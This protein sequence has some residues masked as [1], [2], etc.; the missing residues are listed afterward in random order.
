MKR[1][2]KLTG[3]DQR[4]YA[5]DSIEKAMA[6]GKLHRVTIEPWTE[7]R[8][9]QQNNALHLYCEWL[10]E[11]LNNNGFMRIIKIKGLKKEVEQLWNKSTVKDDLVRPF[12]KA[13]A[14]HD[15]TSKATTVELSRAIENLQDGLAESIGVNIPFPSRFDLMNG[16]RK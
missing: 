14:G 4:N 1:T 11:W 8:T 13:E 2:I 16:V 3:H 5:F 10:A 7:K 15:S 12:V 9:A 6:E